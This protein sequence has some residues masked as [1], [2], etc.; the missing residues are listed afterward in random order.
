MI[1]LLIAGS[2][3]GHLPVKRTTLT[4]GMAALVAAAA[5]GAAVFLARSYPGGGRAWIWMLVLAGGA[6][7]AAMAFYWPFLMSW[8]SSDYEGARLN[9]RFGRYNGAW[10]G[11]G[12]VGPLVGTWLF[13]VHPVLPLIAAATAVLAA[14][15]LL[16]FGR[17]EPVNTDLPSPPAGAREIV[18]DARILADCR[19]LSRIALF[20][21]CICFAIVRSQFALVFRDLGFAESQFG[22][23]LMIYASCNFLALIAA[24]RW[25]FWH[26]RPGLLMVAQIL[27]LLM[28]VMTIYGRTLTVFF[29]ASIILGLAY[30]FAYSSHLYYGASASRKRSTR[31]ALHEMVISLGLTLGSAAGGYLSEHVGLYTPYWFAAGLVGLG[32]IGQV[33]I[34][35]GSRA[36]ARV[37][38]PPPASDGMEITEP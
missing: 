15:L 4:A 16:S 1:A 34:H 35:V 20:S 8:V 38:D 27:F 3:L 32:M 5:M 36:R 2:R 13:E 19:W 37:A 31:M 14:Q 23:Y 30:G 28:L 26:F 25:A 6:G 7:G 18:Y 17:R 9:R 22:V 29:T 10:S 33:A 21:A 11:G 12:T 24:G